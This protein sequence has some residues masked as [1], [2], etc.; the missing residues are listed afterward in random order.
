MHGKFVC[1]YVANKKNTKENCCNVVLVYKILFLLD[2]N[3]IIAL[4]TNL[5]ILTP[6]PIIFLLRMYIC[7]MQNAP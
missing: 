7:S 1:T 3:Q 6:F 5:S 4:L 2:K